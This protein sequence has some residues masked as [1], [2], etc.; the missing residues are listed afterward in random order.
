MPAVTTTAHGP[1][2]DQWMRDLHSKV[3]TAIVDLDQFVDTFD[4][5]H[6]PDDMPL[7][8]SGAP[9]DGC[10]TCQV[11]EMLAIAVPATVEAVMQAVAPETPP[12]GQT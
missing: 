1:L 6:D 3:E 5:T 10:L 4:D 12:K 2:T 11:R 9:Y 7:P 8:P